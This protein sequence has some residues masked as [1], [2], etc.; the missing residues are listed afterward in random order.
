MSCGKEGESFVVSVSFGMNR[1]S[2]RK[3]PA[4]FICYSCVTSPMKIGMNC[5][6]GA[7]GGAT[8]GTVHPIL[9]AYRA[10]R[11]YGAVRTHFPTELTLTSPPHTLKS[12]LKRTAAVFP[13]SRETAEANENR[14]NSRIAL[15]DD[16]E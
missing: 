7:I 12:D 13:T 1:A 11:R 10:K 8:R 4:N 2:S 15:Y 16:N 14:H 5:S 6:S 9:P 3:T